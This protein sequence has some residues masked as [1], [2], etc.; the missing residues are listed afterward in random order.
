MAEVFRVA[1][2]V[3][4][5]ANGGFYAAGAD[6]AESFAVV[7]KQES[8]APG[9]LLVIDSESKRRLTRA[10]EP[11]SPL[12]AGIYSTKPAMIGSPHSI[13]D[14][15]FAAEIPL[16]IVGVVPCKVSTEVPSIPATCWSRPRHRGTRCE[17]RIG[18]ACSEL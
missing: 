14:P 16:A 17:V 15:K 5:F 13:N 12:V 9:D 1:A 11:Y 10:N 8:Y 3:K 4:V 18:R 2:D 6:F 7:G